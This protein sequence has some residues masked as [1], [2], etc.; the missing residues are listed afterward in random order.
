[1]RAYN[2]TAI[3]IVVLLITLIPVR[4]E[5]DDWPNWRGPQH[6]GIS[7]ETDWIGDWP[8][9][10]PAIL[11]E[12]Q[13]GTGFSSIA[14]ADGRVYTMGNSTRMVE[15]PD[16]GGRSG[17]GHKLAE[18]DEIFCLDPNTGEILWIHAY[19]S[20][21]T[22]NLYEGGPSA[23]PT[24][25]DSN[26]YTF[27]K[28]GMAYCLDAN[29]GA[30]L[31]QSD[32]VADYGARIPRYGFAGSPYIDG[33]LVIYNAGTH[34]MALHA[35]DGTLAWET[36]TN[37]AGYSTPVPFDLGEKRYV[38]LM[39]ER[40]F[41]AVEAQTG[42]V[43]WEHPWVTKYNAN[44]PDPIVDSNLVFVSTGYNEGS[45]LFDVATGQV[46][47][48]WFQKN[49][50]TFLNTSVLWQGCLYGPND[51][52]KT[53][54]CVERDT[55]WIIW[56]QAGFGNGSVMLADGK[57]IALSEDG[58]LCIAEA[59]PV[60]YRELGKGRI[61]TGRCWSVPV[62]A[63]GKIYARNAT[64][65]VVCVELVPIG[66][67]MPIGLV[68]HWNLDET[69]GDIAHDSAGEQDGLLFGNPQW[70]PAGGKSNGT[71]EFDGIDDYVS[72]THIIS[73]G[74]GDF[75]VFAWIKGGAAGQA[76]LSQESGAN[77]LMADSVDGALRTD[78]RQPGTT[79]RGATPPG[80][81]LTSATVVTDGDWRRIGFVRDGS[82]RILYVDGIEVARDIA[83]NLELASGGLYIGAGS[84]LEPGS[85]FSGLIDDVRVYNRT[86]KP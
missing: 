57:L 46:I 47:E 9:F 58:E 53:L 56:T 69:E 13:V 85:F 81:P 64:G 43:L 70:R 63:N 27:S 25:A 59:S 22:P 4:T 6:N 12:Q 32:M 5:A 29:D 44:I 28:Q 20:D 45:A 16:A 19:E 62:L 15:D 80:P 66:E 79:G 82:N 42:Q 11:W 71:L 31:W 72:T 54:T 30:V 76:I 33:E 83:A 3:S 48:L 78:L 74:G 8:A 23:T 50:Q 34:G 77:W 41:A 14:V 7:N 61:L 18:V 67:A 40:T 36:G 1:M 24:I 68:A 37:R 60:G 55:G 35:A 86:I 17:V 26:V 10:E 73:P 38:V 84:N 52:D 51:K 21:L 65:H 39:S 2:F 49:M 75:S